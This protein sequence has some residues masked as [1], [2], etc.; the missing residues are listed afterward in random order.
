[1][2]FKQIQWVM[3]NGHRLPTFILVYCISFQLNSA[4]NLLTIEV[5][6]IITSNNWTQCD[7]IHKIQYSTR[8]CYLLLLFA[9][10]YTLLRNETSA[11]W[12]SSDVMA[13][14]LL[15]TVATWRGVERSIQIEWY[16]MVWYGIAIL[17][18]ILLEPRSNRNNTCNNGQL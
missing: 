15:L 5:D 10:Q 17:I 3:L 12:A 2:Q 13:R 6:N 14:L 11:L 18:N 16:G 7:T 1:M 8:C 4:Y 9:I